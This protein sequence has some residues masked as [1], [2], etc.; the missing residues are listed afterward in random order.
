MSKWL[1]KA[2][3]EKHPINT[4]RGTLSLPVSEISKLIKSKLRKSRAVMTLFKQFGVSPDRLDD[5]KI[6]IVDL[7]DKYAETDL[8]VMKLNK[9]L[10][11]EN[12]SFFEEYFYIICHEIF[13]YCNRLAEKIGIV[14]PTDF[15]ADQKKFYFQDEEEVGGM[16]ISVA[17]LLESGAS[18]DEIWNK[19][20]NKINFHFHEPQDGKEFFNFVYDRAKKILNH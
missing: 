9:F 1:A 12:G 5:L 4:E 11:E 15:A 10:F 2:N 19:L 16:V 20:W 8:K 6:E 3:E 18:D 7:E 14:K 13:H 17:F